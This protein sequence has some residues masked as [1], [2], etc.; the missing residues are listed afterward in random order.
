MSLTSSKCSSGGSFL[1]V[2]CSPTVG[3]APSSLKFLRSNKV[4]FSDLMNLRQALRGILTGL[5]S[6]G[7]SLSDS[8]AARFRGRAIVAFLRNLLR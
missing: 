6:D 3:L 7:H 2:D 4:E 8:E 1:L 5:S